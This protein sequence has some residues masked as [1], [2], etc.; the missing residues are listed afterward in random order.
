MDIQ[1][2]DIEISPNALDDHKKDEDMYPPLKA[3]SL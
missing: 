3:L 2:S 1:S